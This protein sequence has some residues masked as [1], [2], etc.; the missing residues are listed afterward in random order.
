[1]VSKFKKWITTLWSDPAVHEVLRETVDKM[2]LTWNAAIEAAANECSAECYEDGT[3][4]C[5]CIDNIR[6]LK[7]TP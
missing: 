7:E 5:N 2:Q 3:P 1:M 4:K 6:A